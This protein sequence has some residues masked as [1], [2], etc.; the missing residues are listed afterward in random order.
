MKD[1][2]LRE[3]FEEWAR[4]LR[5]LPVPAYDGIR[6]RARRRTARFTAMA[7]SVLVLLAAAGVAAGVLAG[8][9][10]GGALHTTPPAGWGAGRYPAPPHQPYVLVIAANGTL[11]LR[12]AAAGRTVWAASPGSGQFVAV[13]AA[14]DDRLFIAARQGANG[15]PGFG[16]VRVHMTATGAAAASLVPVLQHSAVP[17]GAQVTSM[18]LN[19]AGTR[20]ALAFDVPGGALGGHSSLQVYDL[21]TGS[22]IGSWPGP[23]AGLSLPQF[24]G[25][26]NDLTVS[27]PAPG[28]VTAGGHFQ[29]QQ[30]ILATTVPFRAGSSLAADSRRYEIRG[31]SGTLSEDGSVLMSTLDGRVAVNPGDSGAGAQLLLL[32]TA[33][34]RVITNITLG[35]AS[36]AASSK[37]F[38]GV[39]WASASARHLLAQCGT[40]QFAI[41]DGKVTQVRLAWIFSL[42]L[43][44]P[45]LSFAW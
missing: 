33:T 23:A 9:G 17:D 10:T 32:S 2:E 28:S 25:G 4:P 29:L 12:D 24:V 15:Q 37:Y 41:T 42:S 45:A 30:R 7:G 1:T 38:C 27:W 36:A 19:A 43:T 35:P 40:R 13:T 21:T 5:S 8:S 14:P 44:Q 6:R 16:E 39:L 11:A 31:G 20:L 18:A 22:L 26:G 34:G 3:A